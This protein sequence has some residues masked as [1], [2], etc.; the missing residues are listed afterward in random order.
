MPAP[1]RT[2]IVRKAFAFL[3]NQQLGCHYL[4]GAAGATP[5]N[6]DGMF[7]RKNSVHLHPNDSNADR[8]DHGRRHPI[9]FAAT[10]NVDG[11][12]VCS[13]RHKNFIIKLM[14]R[15]DYN[16]A[17][18]RRV[19]GNFIWARPRGRIDSNRICYGEVCNGI[20]HFDC[21]GLVNWLFSELI[22][23][24]Q[25]SIHQWENGSINVGFGDVWPGDILTRP[26][27]V[28]VA[29]NSS[30]VVHA[31]SAAHGVI[32]Q[33]IDPRRWT[34][35]GR[36]PEYFWRKGVVTAKERESRELKGLIGIL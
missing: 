10:C 31:S 34:R 17:S 20:R 13:G 21:V 7:R 32:E 24:V 29:V 14:N 33:K 23:P 36:L 18:H 4:W 30:T 5:G 6:R 27:H 1:E 2:Q 9:L 35:C 8:R 22:R 19:P 26:G 25:Q 3:A 11:H 16:N 15:G 12:Y 28:G